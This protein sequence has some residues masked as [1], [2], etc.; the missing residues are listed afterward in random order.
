[1]QQKVHDL[2]F[3]FAENFILISL[4]KKENIRNPLYFIL[5][6]LLRKE[7]I[8]NPLS[9][10]HFRILSP[11]VYIM[12]IIRSFLMCCNGVGGVLSIFVILILISSANCWAYRKFIKL[13]PLGGGSFYSILLI[14][15]IHNLAYVIRGV[16]YLIIRNWRIDWGFLSRHSSIQTKPF[17]VFYC[18]LCGLKS[19][20]ILLSKA[21]KKLGVRDFSTHSI[22][23][24]FLLLICSC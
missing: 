10:D 21:I 4:P 23:V 9:T 14:L 17:F 7:N 15:D 5:I 3:Y 6:S 16:L 22:V 13:Y 11:Y 24:H 20:I 12:E 19:F 1:M 18:V 8:R 2:I